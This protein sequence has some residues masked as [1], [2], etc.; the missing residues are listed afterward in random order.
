MSDDG[1][2]NFV[3]DSARQEAIVAIANAEARKVEAEYGVIDLWPIAW[4]VFGC[5][6]VICYTYWKLHG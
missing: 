1:K 4:G 2:W 3:S 5:C 6:C